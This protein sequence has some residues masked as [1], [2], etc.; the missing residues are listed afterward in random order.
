M[1]SAVFCG[2]AAAQEYCFSQYYLDKLAVS[3]AFA[4]V[5]D[6]SEIGLIFRD[7]WP[8]IEGG[9]KIYNAEYQQKLPTFNC[10]LGLR[11]FGD[12]SG[13]GAFKTTEADLIYAYEFSLTHSLK[14]S[15][16]IQAGYHTKKLD[17]SGLVYYSMIEGSTGSVAP[18]NENVRYDK[19][20]SVNFSGGMM[21]YTRQT[22]C[23]FGLYRIT[24]LRV[25]GEKNLLPV[26]TTV[27][28]NHKIKVA[29]KV[30]KDKIEDVFIAPTLNFAYSS[31][32][33]MIMPGAYFYGSKLLAGLALRYQKSDWSSAAVVMSA[34]FNFGRFEIGLGYDVYLSAIGPPSKNSVEAGV[35]YKFENSEKN[36]GS[37]TILCPAF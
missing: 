15:F 13:G 36:S 4:A 20:G 10:G 28:I 32:A 18:I 24:S 19:S 5:G 31:S 8:G 25:T 1:F 26:T 9:F 29:S 14:C 16:G 35:K 17:Q 34:G 27:L 21:L 3:P 2:A 37:K 30:R 33:V 11:L 23:A 12:M 6:Y 22:L 7:Q